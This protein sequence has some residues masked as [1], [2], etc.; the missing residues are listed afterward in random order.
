MRRV[1]ARETPK[2]KMNLTF[3]VTVATLLG[4][5]VRSTM[6]RRNSGSKLISI[7][8]GDVKQI[9]DQGRLIGRSVRRPAYCACDREH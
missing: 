8:A 4:G 9:R 6:A 7:K 5:S 1:E 3:G 2:V